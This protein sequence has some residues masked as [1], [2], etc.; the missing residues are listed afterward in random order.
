MADD[1][2]ILSVD[3]LTGFAIFMIA[4]IWVATMVPG[5]FLGLKSS[6]IDYDAVA[7][8]TGVILAEDPGSPESYPGE[9]GSTS[10]ELLVPG[11]KV[12]L[13]RFGLAISKDTPGILDPNKA[14]RFFCSTAFTYPEDYRKFAIFGDYPYMFNISLRSTGDVAARSVGDIIPDAHGYIR[15]AV[16]IKSTSNATIDTAMIKEHGYNN[17]EDVSSHEFVIRINGSKLLHGGIGDPRYQIDPLKDRIVINITGL[18]Q[19]PVRSPL[20]TPAKANLSRIQFY[21]SSGGSIS[22]LAVNDLP[23]PDYRYLY[24]DGAPVDTHP[25]PATRP[26]VEKEVSMIFNPSFFQNAGEHDTIFVNLTF[27]LDSPQQYLN[28]TLSGPF[29]YNYNPANVTQPALRDAVMEVAVW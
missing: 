11:N 28:S 22:S 12:D 13:K 10:W 24:V 7:Y 27:G 8:R 23:T 21:K 16:K 6:T 9:S 26:E 1:A 15:R 5:L 4:F 18:D 25:L 3:F 20:V 19:N 14:D 2:G 17:T 29:D